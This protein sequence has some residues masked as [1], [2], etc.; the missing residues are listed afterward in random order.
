MSLEE[1]RKY[2]QGYFVTYPKEKAEVFVEPRMRVSLSGD[3]PRWAMAAA[4]T[5][6]MIYEQPVCYE[7]AE[8][9]VPTLFIIGQEDHTA[10]G[11][12][13]APIDLRRT[14]GNVP[15]LARKASK[16]IQGS[17]VVELPN[18]GH[19][20]HLEAPDAFFQAVD[21]FLRR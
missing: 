2:I 19:I 4:L 9:K 13:R 17:R 7:F 10:V 8:I 15:E 6:L 1:F 18:V 5:T 12:D 21:D 16:Q 14:L 20:P 3:F 11:R